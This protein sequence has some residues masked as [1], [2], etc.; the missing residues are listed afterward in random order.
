ML[1]KDVGLGVN[2]ANSIKIKPSIGKAAIQVYEKL[3]KYE[4]Y[5][6]L[7]ASIVYRFLGGPE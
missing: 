2:A 3:D 6:D 1:F 7:D 4:R 5:I